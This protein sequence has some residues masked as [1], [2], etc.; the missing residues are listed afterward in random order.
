MR[1]A[2]SDISVKHQCRLQWGYAKICWDEQRHTRCGKFKETHP[3]RLHL[4]Q[5][6]SDG[7]AAVWRRGIAGDADEARG[8]AMNAI[9][10]CITTSGDV[11]S[12]SERF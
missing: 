7:G 6:I 8:A 12:A 9:A 5:A 3:S 1:K 2:S 11:F 4:D 10:Q